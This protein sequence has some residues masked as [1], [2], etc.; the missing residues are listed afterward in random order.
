MCDQQSLVHPKASALQKGNCELI[1]GPVT[2]QIKDLFLSEILFRHLA[3]EARVLRVKIKIVQVR[4]L[5]LSSYRHSLTSFSRN[6][7]ATNAQPSVGSL[8][9]DDGI[10]CIQKPTATVNV[11]RGTR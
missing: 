7:R 1:E 9:H 2:H 3:T 4:V 11:H 6:F 10:T 5:K 8:D